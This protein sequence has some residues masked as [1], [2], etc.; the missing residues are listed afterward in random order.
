[1]VAAYDVLRDERLRESYDKMLGAP[2]ATKREIDR[3]AVERRKSSRPRAKGPSLRSRAGLRSG[4]RMLMG[5]LRVEVGIINQA[6]RRCK[7]SRGS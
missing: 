3:P 6:I 5:S 7:G 1:M 4:S 2:S